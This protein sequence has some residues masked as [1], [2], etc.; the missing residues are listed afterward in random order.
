M[1]RIALPCYG[2]V[3]EADVAKAAGTIDPGQLTH[4][5]FEGILSLVLGHACAGVD[6]STPAYLEG[7]ETAI[8]NV[9]P[10]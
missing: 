2:I 1:Q 3:V 10:D 6:I 9:D 4:P 5:V 7:L 8:E